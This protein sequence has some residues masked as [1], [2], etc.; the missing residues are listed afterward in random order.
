[1]HI[2]NPL[3]PPISAEYSIAAQSVLLLGQRTYALRVQPRHHRSEKH[4]GTNTQPSNDSQVRENSQ[5]ALT[6]LL[7]E[8][9]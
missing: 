2:L 7:R 6:P 4:I 1:M 5:L 8:D 9:G 3:L